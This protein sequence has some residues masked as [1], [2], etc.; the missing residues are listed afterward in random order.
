MNNVNRHDEVIINNTTQ[1]V[2]AR[3]FAGPDEVGA[4]MHVRTETCAQRHP[5]NQRGQPKR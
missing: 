5:P 2:G 4:K 3:S 1:I